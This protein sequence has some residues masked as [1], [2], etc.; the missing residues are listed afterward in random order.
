MQVRWG[1]LPGVDRWL[2]YLQTLSLMVDFERND[3]RSSWIYWSPR[4]CF[5]YIQHEPNMY[6]LNTYNLNT[7]DIIWATSWENLFMPYANNKSAD[8]PAHSRSLISA[9]VVRCLD[10]II[11][12]VSIYEISSPYQV[13]VAAYAGLSLTW[14]QT[15]KTGF[16]VTRLIYGV[17]SL[18]TPY[19]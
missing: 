7:H 3:S 6:V 10:S 5:K 12:L 11:S 15:S 17:W 2:S 19:M 14:S 8:H 1:K 16:L 4:V 13:S 9:F 18:N